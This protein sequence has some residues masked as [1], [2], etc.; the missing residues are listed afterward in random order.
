MHITLLKG[1]PRTSDTQSHDGVNIFMQTIGSSRP[2]II[3]RSVSLLLGD[4]A[5]K[6]V[7]DGSVFGIP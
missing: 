5:P 1:L 2:Q 3:R 7:P 6:I 4:E